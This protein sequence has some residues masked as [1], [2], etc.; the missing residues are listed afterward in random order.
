MVQKNLFFP[1]IIFKDMLCPGHNMVIMLCPWQKIVFM[2]C[3]GHNI[4]K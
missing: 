4:R 3:L 1:K 2:L